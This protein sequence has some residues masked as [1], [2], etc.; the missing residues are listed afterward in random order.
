MINE[1]EKLIRSMRKR[2]SNEE[3]EYAKPFFK[4]AGGKSQLLSEFDIRLPHEL[5]SGIIDRYVEP[6][7]G[8]GAVFF[9]I[10][11]LIPLKE[12]V[13]CDANEELILTYQVVKQDVEALISL[14]TQYQKQYDAR[15]ESERKEMFLRIRAD[16]NAARKGFDFSVY[17][18][19]WV[20]RAAMLLFLNKTCFNGLFRVNSKG[21]F[22]VPFGKYKNPGI[23]NES[24]LRKASALLANTTILLGDF[25]RCSEYIDPKTFVYVDPP[26]RPLN[27]TSSFT[28]YS[29]GGFS[30]QD[31]VR[32]SEFFARSD[33]IGARV[34]LSNSDPKNEDPADHFFDDLYQEYRIDRVQAK[35]FINCDA[36]KRGEISEIIVMN[37]QIP[38]GE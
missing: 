25:T 3:N 32:L 2:R 10:T 1:S 5:K 11:Q 30:D 12:A 7:V 21:E 16:M 14:L 22:N 31:Q 26:Y 18:D 9:F 17:G 37:Y 15:D 8:G 4:W 38:L 19:D 36:D 20:E 29:M 28:S 27:D 34:M 6:F 24:N 23:V 33:Q 35:R 13:I